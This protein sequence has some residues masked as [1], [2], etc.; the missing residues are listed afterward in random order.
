MTTHTQDCKYYCSQ[1]VSGLTT[2]SQTNTNTNRELHGFYMI[3]ELIQNTEL[4]QNLIQDTKLLQNTQL[5]RNTK[6]I[7][8]YFQ[9][10]VNIT[11]INFQNTVIIIQVQMSVTY[12]QSN[13]LI[14]LLVNAT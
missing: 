14:K 13:V 2:C 6:L 8:K 7:Q 4:L 1:R 5:L 11:L 10:L 3:S 12:C 9:Y